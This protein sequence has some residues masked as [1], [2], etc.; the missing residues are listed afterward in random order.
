MD[1]L[2]AQFVIEATELTQQAAEDLLALDQEPGNR[3]KLDSAFR[4]IH[5]LKGSVGLFDLAPMQSA[6]HAAEDVLGVAIKDDAELDPARIDP[7]LAVIEW[8]D[9]CVQQLRG[10]GV[11]PSTAAD[12]GANLVLSLASGRAVA[13][14]PPTMTGGAFPQWA[15]RLFE[16]HPPSRGEGA[17]A[18]RYAPAPECFFNGDDPVA[19]MAAVPGVIY[20]Q[21]VTREDWPAPTKLDPFRSNLIFEGIST[22]KRADIEAVFR[23]IPDQIAIAQDAA[24]APREIPAESGEPTART[25]RVD[26]ARMDDIVALVGELVTAKN[27]MSALA[28]QAEALEGGLALSRNVA[29]AQQDL[30]RLINQLQRAATDVRM[31]PLGG[32]LR[33]LARLAREISGQT[34]KP[35]QLD[36]AGSEIEADKTIVDGLYE[37]LLHIIRNAVD[38]GIEPEDERQVAGKPAKGMIS[39]SAR[40]VGHRIELQVGDDGRGIDPERIR[41]VALARGMI[42]ADA[43]ATLAEKDSLELLFIPGFSTSDAVSDLSG[44]GVGMDA[45]R[46]A[47]HRLGG[48][49]AISSTAGKGTT[50]TLSLPTSFTM[51][52]VMLVHIAGE[53]YGVPMQAIAETVKIPAHAIVRVRSG[54]AFVLRDRTIPI[55]R[56]GD[57]LGRAAA[58][59]LDELVLILELG[60]AVVG[61]VVDGV[62]E[63]FETLL[64]PPAGL[65]K[66]VSG[67]LGTTVQGDGRIVMVL[68]LEALLA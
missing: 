54:E 59:R 43:A 16:A 31:V 62:G 35:L 25:I 15:A 51:S 6:L 26:L 39:V 9:R 50:I 17:I 33:R 3:A 11:L 18:L 8:I 24:P 48:K 61:L 49:V 14:L 27:G 52:R 68:D 44:R 23:L 10:V 20:A 47:V 40:Q 56:L 64:R 58:A 2:L 19:L 57:I 32:T 67:V 65:L 63:R 45:V 38:H 22:A 46:A 36:V 7:M 60:T 13:P 66:S 29:A 21:V 34:G 1:D 42:S 30:G 5:T 4:A 53:Q 12:E 37:P 28:A 55:V 41:S